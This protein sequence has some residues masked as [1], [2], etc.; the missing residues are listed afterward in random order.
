[1]GFEKL[2]KLIEGLT[3]VELIEFT[4]KENEYQYEKVSTEGLYIFEVYGVAAIVI[5]YVS[6]H[7]IPC[8][9]IVHLIPL[10]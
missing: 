8:Q 6:D 10:T 3:M 9:N 5:D 7:D 4:L 1:M 2:Q